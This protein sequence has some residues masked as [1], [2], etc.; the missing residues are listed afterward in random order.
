[1]QSARA[2]TGTS[3]C[4]KVRFVNPK[5]SIQMANKGRLKMG[6]LIC[7]YFLLKFATEFLG[8]RL[9]F[10]KILKIKSNCSLKFYSCQ[11]LMSV[12]DF[13]FFLQQHFKILKSVHICIYITCRWMFFHLPRLVIDCMSLVT[14]LSP[15]VCFVFLDG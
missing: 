8:V 5:I 7:F 12:Y 13:V 10:L 9:R 4:I 3:W 1:M 2:L 14:S 6:I 11:A 15:V